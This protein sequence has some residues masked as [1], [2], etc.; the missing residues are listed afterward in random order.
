VADEVVRVCANARFSLLGFTSAYDESTLGPF[1]PDHH[2]DQSSKNRQTG[3]KNHCGCMVSDLHSYTEEVRCSAPPHTGSIET[4]RPATR[5][6]S[7]GPT[8]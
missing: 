8:Q 2:R 5:E 1:E 6:A 4:S 3:K 7:G